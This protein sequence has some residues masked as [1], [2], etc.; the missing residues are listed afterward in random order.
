[1]SKQILDYPNQNQPSRFER[2]LNRLEIGLT[3]PR[4]LVF[5][6]LLAILNIIL[7]IVIRD[8]AGILG[9]LIRLVVLEAMFLPFA[10]YLAAH[11]CRYLFF[12]RS[13]KAFVS[14]FTFLLFMLVNLCGF[15]M[16]GMIFWVL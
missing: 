2:L 6:I 9:I 11:S 7:V 13:N 5:S 15:F 14:W 12:R 3:K 1:M 4:L 10:C 8:Q 16:M